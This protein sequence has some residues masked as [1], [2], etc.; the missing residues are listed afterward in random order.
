MTQQIKNQNQ[1]ETKFKRHRISISIYGLYFYSIINRFKQ[2]LTNE[3]TTR[4][5]ETRTPR[6]DQRRL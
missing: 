5:I 3:N 1:N 6:I 4:K 2:I